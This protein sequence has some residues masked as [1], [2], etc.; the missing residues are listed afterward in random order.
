MNLWGVLIYKFGDGF[1]RALGDYNINLESQSVAL[2]LL[3]FFIFSDFV[4]F[5]SH[6]FLHKN[7]Y[8][9]K[10]HQLHHSTETLTTISAFRHHW[11][12]ELYH[13]T[14]NT[15]LACVLIVDPQVRLIM[16]ILITFACYF[17]HANLKIHFPNWLNSVLI[18]PLNHRWHHSQENIKSKGQN[19]GLFLSIWD[20]WLGSHHVPPQEPNRLGTSADYPKTLGRRLIYPFIK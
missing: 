3:I 15:I 16:A 14:C 8:L 9:W 18:T 20:R 2:Q 1:S 17:Q 6:R 19:F 5:I 12:E 13:I 4:S 10:F 7:D 11:L